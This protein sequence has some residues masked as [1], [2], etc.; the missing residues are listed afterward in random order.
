MWEYNYVSNKYITVL[1]N[2]RRFVGII[3]VT[4]SNNIYVGSP[5]AAYHEEANRK[6]GRW[7]HL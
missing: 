6:Y 1:F 2:T 4:N 5:T 3:G 7:R